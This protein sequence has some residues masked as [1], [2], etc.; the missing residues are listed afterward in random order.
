MISFVKSLF[1]SV[2]LEET[3]N[4]ALDRI[5]QQKEI[6]ISSNKNGMRNLL[7]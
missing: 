3:I 5:Y 4:L 1:T 2:T 7:L 6:D